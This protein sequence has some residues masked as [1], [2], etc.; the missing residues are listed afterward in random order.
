MLLNEKLYEQICNWADAHAEEM[1]LDLAKL[2]RIPSV[3]RAD[4]AED[5]APFGKDVRKM[6]DAALEMAAGY[7]FETQDNEGYYGDAWA[8]DKE[9]AIGIISHLDVVPEGTGWK[10]PPFG[11][12]REG[13]FL[14]GRGVG[15]N[16]SAAVTAI[17]TMRMLRDIEAP[18][19]N[20]IRAIF[21]CSEET[22]MQDMPHMIEKDAVPPLSLVPDASFPV[23]YAQKGTMRGTMSIPV[24]TDILSFTGG[25]VRNMVPP[26]AECALYLPASKV[27]PVFDG[28]EEFTVTEE[29]GIC[30]VTAKGLAA[31]AAAPANGINAIHLLSEALAGSGLLSEV[32]QKA[33]HALSAMTADHTGS[34]AGIACEDPESGAT[35][36]V[37]G[38]ARTEEGRIFLSL[39]CRLSIAADIEGNKASFTA[40]AQSLGMRVD[41]LETS[42]PFYMPKD[43]IRIVTLNRI[44]EE[45]LHME[46]PQPYTMGGGTYSRVVPNAITFGT[47]I[48]SFGEKL[49]LGPGHGGAH[50]PDEYI[51]L[52]AMKEAL[53]AMACAV[54]L[55]DRLI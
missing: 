28:R 1:Y 22:G 55:L 53:K 51:Y 54:I 6:L 10:Y 52:P 23:N 46:N 8:G 12:T 16:K 24:G 19:T 47:G 30:R 20:G 15:D 13:D 33:M 5:N 49:D 25:E 43:D 42:A 35:T 41:E 36:M 27:R 38:V 14:I 29:A 11:A 34:D 26:L 45:V 50:Q 31:H 7:G 18:I 40:F 32:S 21:G 3:S 44:C 2:S 48:P 4:L 37:C 17:Y 39:D 9:K